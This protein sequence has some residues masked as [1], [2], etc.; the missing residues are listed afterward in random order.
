LIFLSIFAANAEQKTIQCEYGNDDWGSIGSVY[1]C[2][3]SSDPAITEFL[4]ED[5]QITGTHAAGKTNDD[6]QG[7]E[8]YECQMEYFPRGLDKTF[9]NLRGI[10]IFRAGLKAI[11]KEDLEPFDKLKAL[12]LHVNNIEV[13]EQD[14]FSGNPKLEYLN[15]DNNQIKF[16]HLTVFENLKNLKILWLYFNTCIVQDV[17]N[18]PSGVLA[19]I[20]TAK[21]QC[22]SDVALYKLHMDNNPYEQMRQR[23]KKKQEA[24][25]ERVQMKKEIK[26]LKEQVKALEDQNGQLKIEQDQNKALQY[27][28]REQVKALKDQN[29]QLKIE[30]DQNK[31]IQD[32]LREQVKALEDQKQQLKIEQEQ[33]K[34][35]QDTLR[36]Q[37]KALEDQDE[38]RLTC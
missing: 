21:D 27:T 35:I 8:C 2:N 10:F 30:Q 38:L 6:V 1:A 14:L 18:N 16:I 7:F 3:V 5:V 25:R 26:E 20:Q 13:L 37:V 29:G 17:A 19:L 31:A 12:W 11:F 24:K 32:T 23:K 4:T 36:E 34:A 22:T 15:L 33:N 9:K 28:L